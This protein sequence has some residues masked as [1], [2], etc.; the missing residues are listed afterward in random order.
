MKECALLSLIHDKIY[1]IK[2]QATDTLI[3]QNACEL[4]Y[5]C[6]QALKYLVVILWA[7]LPSWMLNGIK[8]SVAIS[9][10]FFGKVH[11][12]KSGGNNGYFGSML[13][14]V[15]A[16]PKAR[17]KISDEQASFKKD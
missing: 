14:S 6:F 12:T 9:K 3:L 2:T 17:K 16:W 13:I 8:Q 4:T 15:Y 7:F 10:Q 11:F 5:Q 1:K